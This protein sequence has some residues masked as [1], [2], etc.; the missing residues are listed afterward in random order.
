MKGEIKGFIDFLQQSA[1]ENRKKADEAYD[2]E[3][4]GLAGYYRGQWIANEGA[5]IALKNLLAKYKE[6]EQ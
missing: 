4:L 3:D 6:E 1:V 5:A 2:N